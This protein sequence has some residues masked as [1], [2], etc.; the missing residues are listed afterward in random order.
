[1]GLIV[2]GLHRWGNVPSL[3]SSEDFHEI[4]AKMS[5]LLFGLVALGASNARMPV[6]GSCSYF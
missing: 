3:Q 6:L 4:S 2:F 1:L 5:G